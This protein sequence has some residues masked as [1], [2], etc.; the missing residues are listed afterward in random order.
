MTERILD[1]LV[2]FLCGLFASLLAAIFS[3]LKKREKKAKLL[4]DGVVSLLRLEIV[5]SYN[6][7]NE[8]GYCPLYARESL[9]RAYND[10]QIFGTK[11]IP[12]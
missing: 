3:M 12:Y 9:T 6:E 2:P 1:W 8:K 10:Y 4:E 7:Y 5:R 11:R